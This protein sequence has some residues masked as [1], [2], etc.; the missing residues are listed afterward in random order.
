MTNRSNRS[1]DRVVA[2]PARNGMSA[3]PGGEP[4]RR[5]AAVRALLGRPHPPGSLY[6]HVLDTDSRSVPAYLRDARPF[7]GDI[8]EVPVDRYISEEFHQVEVERLWKRVW[9]M[10]CREDEIP[11]VGDAIVYDVADLSFVVVRV[12][13]NV[14]KAYVNA[15]LH[16]GEAAARQGAVRGSA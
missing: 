6:G 8:V 9:Q 14:V 16:R 12:A 7:D 2:Q 3:S 11:E 1:E 10:A 5:D 15:C 13:S 4:A